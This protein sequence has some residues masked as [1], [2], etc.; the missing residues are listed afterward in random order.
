MGLHTGGAYP[1]RFGALLAAGLL[2]WVGFD[3]KAHPGT[4]ARVTAV[5]NSAAP[6]VRSL[7]LLF[8][9]GV[10]HRIRTT[11][12]PTLLD[13]RDERRLGAWLAGQGVRAHERQEAR[14]VTRPR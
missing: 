5:R 8:D 2:D 10:E 7:R 9:S 14:P 6:A 3:V 12:D 4:Y 11:V 1:R 13:E